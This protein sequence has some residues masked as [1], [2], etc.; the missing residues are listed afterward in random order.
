M[1]GLH[2]WIGSTQNLLAQVICLVCLTVNFLLHK[3][4]KF[5]K[6]R[7]EPGSNGFNRKVV[8]SVSLCPCYV[9]QEFLSSQLSPDMSLI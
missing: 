1:D 4:R 9:L 8:E 7:K 3:N 6:Q 2:S 5:T